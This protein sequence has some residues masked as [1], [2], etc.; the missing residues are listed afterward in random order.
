MVK[1]HIGS[2]GLA[3]FAWVQATVNEDSQRVQLRER[4]WML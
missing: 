4:M 2:D 1:R 3:R